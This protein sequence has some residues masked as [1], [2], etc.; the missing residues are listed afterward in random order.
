MSTLPL[1]P[2]L[3]RAGT[4]GPALAL[5]AVLGLGVLTGCGAEDPQNASDST[6]ST[7]DPSATPSDTPSADPSATDTTATADTTAVGLYFVGETPQGDRLYRDFQDVAGD[8]LQ[9]ALDALLEGAPSDPDYRALA[10]AG[11]LSGPK[12]TGQQITVSLADDGAAERPA[13][14]DAADATLAVQ[15]VVLTLQAAA[16]SAAPVQV[17]S[18]DGSPTTYLGVDT[19][20]GVAADP[21]LL[22]LVNL[23]TPAQSQSASGSLAVEGVA[24]SF[25]ANVPW[26]IHRGGADGPEVMKG[27]FTAE[28]WM[29]KLYPFTGSIDISGLEPGDY[30]L[31]VTTDDASGGEGGGPQVDTRA[32]TVS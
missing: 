2:R 30:T 22:A 31:Q 14:L 26:S 13:G 27:F 3:A 24:N 16:G 18:S 9:G 6:D 20:A 4:T 15:S 10:P 23:T 17:L 7:G 11:S 5:A 28:G 19:A 25:E 12:V 29:D 8:P 32:I 21:D 1:L